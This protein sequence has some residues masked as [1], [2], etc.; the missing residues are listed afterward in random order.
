[1]EKAVFYAEYQ[2]INFTGQS[3]L[4]EAIF[5]LTYFAFKDMPK[6]YLN[7]KIKVIHVFNLKPKIIAYSLG[8]L[9]FYLDG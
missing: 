3:G 5:L 7:L 6:H 1:M 8:K 2:S 9:F 4:Y